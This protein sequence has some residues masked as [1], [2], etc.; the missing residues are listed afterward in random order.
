MS[1][2]SFHTGPTIVKAMAQKCREAG[3]TV[4][5]EGTERVYVEATDRYHVLAE[6][7][8]VHGTDFG[9]R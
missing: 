3:L 8:R 4:T 6:L 9:L 1:V 7:R 5:C 2:Q